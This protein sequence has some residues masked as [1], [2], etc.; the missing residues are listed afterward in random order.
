MDATATRRPFFYGWVIVAAC[1]VILSMHTGLIYTYG[2]FF[3]HLIADFGWSRAA[4]SGVH[5]LFMF[6]HGAFAIAMGWLTDRFGPAKV[7][8]ACAF[9]GGVGLALTSQVNTLWQLYI[10]YGLIFGIGESAGFAITTATTARWFIKRRGL[11]LG[12]VASGSG[13][14]VLF[15][16]PVTERLIAAFD[17]SIAYLVLAAAT[18]IAMIPSALFLRRDPAEKGLR[19]YGSDGAITAVNE[20]EQIKA[21]TAE[22]GI[23][24]RVAARYKPLW[25]IFIVYFLFNFCLQMVMVHLFNYA[26][27]IGIT[28]LIAATFISI[29]GIGSFFG[30]LLMGIASDRIGAN[31]ALLI[32]CAIMMSTLILLI[33]TR[34]L[35][36][37]YLFAIVFGFAYG[38]EVPQV[39]VLIGQ[40][41]GLRAVATLVGVIVFGATVG[42]GIGAWV[43][44]KVFD[45]TLS[46]QLAFTIAAVASFIAVVLT[47]MLKKSKPVKPK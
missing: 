33:F 27:D 35:W 39:P 25:M 22:P 19:P 34:E 24:L 8:A 45:L 37:F 46:Y 12:I 32:C 5:S 47:L 1:L 31:N 41:F 16:A 18:W 40:F 6:S 43:G 4:T 13:I 2:V 15:I 11:A 17:W 44:G 38:G 23:H 28:S 20:I 7:M 10:T 36:M 26:T 21:N 30:R 14:G 3:K 9:I 29:I 42:G